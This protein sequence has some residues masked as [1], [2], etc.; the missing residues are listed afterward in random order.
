[1]IN[2]YNGY[3][4]EITKAFEQIPV[5]GY[6]CVIKNAEV[7]TYDWGDVLK[8]SCDI[9]EGEYKGWYTKQWKED[10][11]EDKKWGCDL[12]INIP[13]DKSKYIDSD[14]KR[15]NNLIGC[16]EDANTG[17]KW[18][19]DESKLKNKKLALVFR[20]EEWEYEGKT[21]WKVKPF[22]V[23]S[24]GD[25]LDGKWGK[26][27]DK[28]LKANANSTTAPTTSPVEDDGELPWID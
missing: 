15:F 7:L 18:D 19:W 2:K 27:E 10:T 14:T 25:C 16:L 24:I 11:R 3:K 20:N 13:T 5:G 17:F 12:R 23:I 22:K 21:G 4:S 9:S 28:P 8:L 1:M 26:Y 6:V